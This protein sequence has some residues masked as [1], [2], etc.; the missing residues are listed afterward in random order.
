MIIQAIYYEQTSRLGNKKFKIDSV[1]N[2]AIEAYMCYNIHI[3]SKYIKHFGVIAHIS[4]LC[5]KI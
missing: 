4:T 3:S 1:F 5:F 2:I